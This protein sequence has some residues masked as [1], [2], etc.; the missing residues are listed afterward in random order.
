MQANNSNKQIR[1]KVT[2]KKG[3]NE[4]MSPTMANLPSI[5]AAK[6]YIN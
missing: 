2:G 4:V 6:N 3:G 1:L 5:V